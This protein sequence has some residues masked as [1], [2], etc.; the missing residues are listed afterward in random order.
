[1]AWYGKRPDILKL[2]PQSIRLSKIWQKNSV[3]KVEI[4]KTII[5]V[6]PVG[7]EVMIVDQALPT[8][9]PYLSPHIQP[10][11]QGLSSSRP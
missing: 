1:M 5:S 8:D 2:F 11:S 10:R 6:A 9:A 7:Y 3:T 4:N